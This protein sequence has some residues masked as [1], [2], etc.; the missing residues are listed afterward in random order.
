[1]ANFFTDNEDI[2]FLFEHIDLAELARIQEDDFVHAHSGQCDYAPADAADAVDNYRRILEIIG[3]VGGE[4]IAPNAEQIDIEGNTLNEDGTVTL[5]PLVQQNLDR[6]TQADMMGFTLPYKY[7][8]LNCPNL[9]YTMATE[10]V[11]RADCSLMNLFGLQGIAETIYAF[12]NDELKDE[13]LPRFARGEVTG[14][15]V[16]T[17]PD[18]GSDLQA[19]RLRAYQDDEG[20]WYLNGV[21]RFITNGCGEILLVLA[22][23]EPEIADGRGLSLLYTERS[24]RIKVRHLENKLGIHGSPTCEL[25]FSDAPAKLVGERQRG[26]I[27]Y[28]LALMNGA[29]V[30]I[31]AQSLGVAEAAYRLARTY[32]HSRQQFGG[33]IERLPAVAEMV[34]DMK[35][36]LEAARALTY[37]TSRVCDHENNNLR[38]L[39]WGQ[40]DKDEK[41]RR[42][43]LS[44]SFKR[45][46][47]MLTPMSKY[48][49]SE[50]ACTVA[51]TAIQV[52][53]GSGYMKDYP[54]E[55]YLRDARITTIYEGTSQL[56]LVAAVRGVSSGA[57]ETWTADYDEKKYGDPVLDELASRLA[58]A[59]QQVA[60][61]IAFVKAQGISYLDLSSRRLVDA[62]LIVIIGH[63]FLSQATG[64]ERKKSV[65][66]RF[67]TREIPVLQM[68]CR[69]IL[70]GD[71]SP[72]EQYAELAGPVPT[73]E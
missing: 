66:R 56:Q 41:K 33:P 6:L 4:M 43:Q 14:A 39:E 5:H 71:T 40:L 28:V 35:I 42:K 50:M 32:A 60:E 17:E 10:I 65:A 2:Q 8:G 25:V 64:S 55:R 26:L 52:L 59:K 49:A 62:A 61:A 23:T 21:K 57:F 18:A 20:N 48:Y 24:E 68:N 27:T 45:L 69:Q 46:N 31:A 11:S 67:I 63:L 22:R 54:A 58:E 13:V 9:V 51:D 72:L 37:E 30:G 47:A 19:V 36:H 12:A 53:G 29:R 15:M 7:G 16:L 70:S 38:L 34:T 73:V 3:E 1:M 44:R